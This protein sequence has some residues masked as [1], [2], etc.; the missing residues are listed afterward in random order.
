M[1]LA[2]TARPD[3]LR[4]PLSTAPC[5][6][7]RSNDPQ[8]KGTPAPVAVLPSLNERLAL[9][10]KQVDRCVGVDDQMTGDEFSQRIAGLTI[11]HCEYGDSRHE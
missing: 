1:N 11:E 7:Q 3:T 2:C 8:S 4:Q 9:K 10:D 6:T 5:R